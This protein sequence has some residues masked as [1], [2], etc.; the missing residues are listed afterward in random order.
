MSQTT[1]IF[2]LDNTLHNASRHAFPVIN[3]AMSSYLA[4]SL[5]ITHA[6]ASSLR[7]SYWRRYGA[8]LTGL[9]RHHPHID[10]HHFLRTVHPLDLLTR[11]LHPMPAL[12][13][14]LLRLHGRKVL[15][16]NGTRHYAETLLN[17]LGIADCFDAVVGVDDVALQPKPLIGAYRILLHRLQLD[18]RHCIM[19][20]DSS[21]NLIPA[22][23]LGMRTVWLRR[24]ARRARGTDVLIRN[25]AELP[26]RF[27][28]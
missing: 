22:K 26:A 23:R 7:Q 8:T 25:L 6:E 11:E 27:P 2:D 15:F 28:H 12:R 13:R 4:N 21:R 20:E 14:T 17:A 1:W 10:P 16:T 9:M 18:P 3:H 5:G 24:T 19:V